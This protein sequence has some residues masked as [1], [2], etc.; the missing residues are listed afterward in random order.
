[1]TAL[2]EASAKKYGD[3]YTGNLIGRLREAAAK[4]RR[5]GGGAQ[6]DD[7]EGDL[8]DVGVLAEPGRSKTMW[9]YARHVW[10]NL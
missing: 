9:D 10:K 6:A 8:G 5:L 4:S 2:G 7:L 3:L 1:M